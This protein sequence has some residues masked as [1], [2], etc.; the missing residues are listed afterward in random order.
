MAAAAD[1]QWTGKFNPVD[2]TERDFQQ[3]YEAAL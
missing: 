2:L 1:K 3:L